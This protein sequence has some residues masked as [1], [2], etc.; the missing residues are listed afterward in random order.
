MP[1]L[2]PACPIAS[3]RLLG[4]RVTKSGTKNVAS[5]PAEMI[6]LARVFQRRN[7]K[8][9]EFGTENYAAVK[10]HPIVAGLRAKAAKK[11]K[12]G[13]PQTASAKSPVAKFPNANA[14]SKTSTTACSIP[15]STERL[16]PAS[17]KGP[18]KR[19]GARGQVC[20]GMGMP[21]VVRWRKG[22]LKRSWI[23]GK[24]KTGIMI[25]AGVIKNAQKR[26]LSVLGDDFGVIKLAAVSVSYRKKL[27]R[28]Q[29]MNLTRNMARTCLPAMITQKSI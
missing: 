20:G 1:K 19:T 27:K 21:V 4:V 2:A 29:L 25:S 22:A 16:A 9:G 11:P 24:D 17:A 12:P 3:K 14:P 7:A 23:V 26:K 13:T 18:K 28:C 10:S 5:A 8:K 6:W 15:P